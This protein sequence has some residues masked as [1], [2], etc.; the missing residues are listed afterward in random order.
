MKKHKKKIEFSKIILIGVSI[1]TTYIVLF[2]SYMIWETKDLTPLA[3]L[4]P[5]IFTELATAT[6]F[7]F[8]KSKAENKI[9]LMKS[10]GLPVTEAT[11]NNDQTNNQI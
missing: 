11:I 7:Y 3:Y 2:S 9:K 6:A 4:I 1:L 10:L 5:A 8:N